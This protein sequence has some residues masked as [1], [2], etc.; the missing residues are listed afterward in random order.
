MRYPI[1]RVIVQHPCDQRDDLVHYHDGIIVSLDRR[2]ALYHSK[3]AEVVPVEVIEAGNDCL[4]SYPGSSN[5]DQAAQPDL[6]R[7]LAAGLDLLERIYAEEIDELV[8]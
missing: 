6:P 4:K 3:L 7:G 8:R 1:C 5:T 2:G